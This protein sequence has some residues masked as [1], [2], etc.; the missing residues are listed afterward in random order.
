MFVPLHSQRLLSAGLESLPPV[1][2]VN[3]S[4]VLPEHSEIWKDAEGKRYI[5]SRIAVASA[6]SNSGSSMTS[7][8]EGAAAPPQAIVYDVRALVVQVQA[9]A[10]ESS[11]LI[12][13][14]KGEFFRIIAD[15]SPK[16]RVVCLQ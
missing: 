9:A 14:V 4:H 3:V 10:D 5:P 1:I 2:S 7:L 6:A 11:H 12:S 13:F 8:E 15:S 16:W